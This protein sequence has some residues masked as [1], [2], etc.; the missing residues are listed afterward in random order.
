LSFIFMDELAF[1]FGANEDT[2]QYVLDY[3]TVLLLFSLFLVWD[4]SLIV[5]VGNDGNPNLAMFGLV[6]TSVFNIGLNYWMIF[7]LKLGV[8]GAALAT[9]ISIVIGWIILMAHFFKKDKILSFIK[10]SF[11]L[12]IIKKIHVVGFPS[13]LAEA[14]M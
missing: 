12:Q 2:F 1:I 7:I 3:M 6:V 13:F 11:D 5:L 10:P 4:T 9:G 14:G 8:T